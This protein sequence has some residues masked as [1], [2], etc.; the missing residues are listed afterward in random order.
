MIGE[1]KER[2]AQEEE[3]KK[4]LAREIEE[5]F[6]RRREERRRV[7][8]SWTLNIQFVAGNQYCDLTPA[9]ALEEEDTQFFWQTHRVFNHIAPTVDSRIAKLVQARPTVKAVP[10]SDEDG[11][12]RAA[13]LCTGVIAYSFERA[14]VYE[15][16]ADGVIWSETCGS[17]FYKVVW[18]ENAGR[19]AGVDAE[20]KPIYEGEA[21]VCAIPPYEIFPDRL[22]C[23][24]S[25]VQSLI[26]AQYVSVDK[27]FSLYGVHVE[28]E[29]EEDDGFAGVGFASGGAA[30]FATRGSGAAFEGGNT[31]GK[32]ERDR[33]ILLERYTLPSAKAER[34]RLEIA[35]GGK[36]LYEGDLPYE[37][38]MHGERTFPFVKQDCLKQPS[39]FFGTSVV[40]RLV[41]VQR[42]YNAVRNRKHEFLN[43]IAAGVLAVED[44]SVDSDALAEEG[45]APGKILVYR[46]GSKAPEM[47][48]V[49]NLPAD[50]AEEEAWLEKEFSVVSGVSDLSQSSTPTRVTSATGLQ[51][52]LSQDDSR[53]Y[54]SKENM[55]AALK[56]IARHT[57]RLYKQF[58]GNARLLRTA[59][60]GGSTQTYYFNAKDLSCDDILIRT[61][62]TLGD[63]E[64]KETILNLLSAGILTDDDGKISQ[65]NKNRILDA[66]GLG[67]YENCRDISALH[68]DVAREENLK[69]LNGAGESVEADDLDDHEAHIAEHCRFYFSQE[70]RSEMSKKRRRALAM[71]VARHKA[72]AAS[73]SAGVAEEGVDT[74][75]E[76]RESVAA[77]GEK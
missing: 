9:G 52:L 65:E 35:A 57:V 73:G 76:A 69:F 22:D 42:A 71:H 6:Y 67:S 72:L 75:G 31:R 21:A 7:E 13:Q 66:F 77:D 48:D 32:G 70:G 37:N 5:D 59:G 49:G 20:G 74:D 33:C 47:L 40:D 15:A 64:R 68:A 55:F 18:D 36:L 53:M 30:A 54:A 38:G 24:F 8:N 43:R 11:D 28:G 4:R 51:L 2:A 25:A 29:S 46:Q 17:V 63:T 1:E 62:E 12:L 50:F 58:A 19:K 16:I 60:E 61:E 3:R 34:G 23:D 45:L 56:E 27:I 41:P 44:G 14:R 39:G 26:H 10:F